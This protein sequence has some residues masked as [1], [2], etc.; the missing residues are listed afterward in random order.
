MVINK[1]YKCKLCGETLRIRYQI[2][3]CK[4]PI[5]IYCPRCNTHFNGAISP[6]EDLSILFSLNNVIECDEVESGGYIIE[7][8][9]EFL[10]LKYQVNESRLFPG[11]TPFMRYR[12]KNSNDSNDETIQRIIH[13]A[14]ESNDYSNQI[15]TL[16]NLLNKNDISLIR[17]YLNSL[18][19]EYI[20]FFKSR[21]NLD[22]ISTKL[23][24]LLFVKQYTKSLIGSSLL[25]KTNKNINTLFKS[26]DT[27]RNRNDINEYKRL[28]KYLNENDY[29]STMLNE[30][31]K[32]VVSYIGNFKQ[33]V[34]CYLEYKNA[35][36]IDYNEIGISSADAEKM[37]ELY[38]NGFELL[39][40]IIDPSIAFD[41]LLN[42]MCFDNFGNGRT[43]FKNELSKYKSKYNKVKHFSELDEYVCC[44]FYRDSLNNGIRNPIA[45]YDWKING[46]TQELTFK[47]RIKGIETNIYLTE[48]VFK[49][50]D[51][52]N[53]I[54]MAWEVI[55][56]LFKAKLLLIDKVGFNYR[57]K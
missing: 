34:P 39:G 54:F 53:S 56:Q 22:S 48:L 13:L 12:L 43:N 36:S 17:N 55:Y 46:L 25:D 6:K 26:L 35:D 33:F 38:S 37:C 11:L 24:Y 2:G 20:S 31:P 8:S 28:L 4:M 41:N 42:R 40:R 30:I 15:E 49:C 1:Y 7:L 45:H 9:P 5:N 14:V 18:N 29:F 52:F 21:S 44:S 32:Y 50:I 57:F 47:D 27:I 51:V 10:T 23:D 3:Y 16:F 19:N